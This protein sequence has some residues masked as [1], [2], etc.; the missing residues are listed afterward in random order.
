M[1]GT[2]THF[3]EVN[4]T[5]EITQKK[6]VVSNFSLEYTYRK[7]FECNTIV[8]DMFKNNVVIKNGEIAYFFLTCKRKN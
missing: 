5:L 4:I 1:L 7:Y 2:E 6:I 8:N 3:Y